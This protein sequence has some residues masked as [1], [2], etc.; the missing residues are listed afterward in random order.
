MGQVTLRASTFLLLAAGLLLGSSGVAAAAGAAD[1]VLVR[2]PNGGIQP[3]AALDAEGNL[4][5]IYFKGT[6]AAG[7]VFYVKREAGADEFSTPLQVNSEAGSAVA[8]GTI[9]G[10]QLAIGKNGRLH[11]A[12][13]GSN[14]AVPPDRKGENPMLYSRLNDAQAAFEPQRNVIQKAYGLDGGGS[15]AADREGNVFV[16]WHSGTTGEANRKV[17][18]VR[19]SDEGA[20][21]SPEQPGSSQATGA[22]GC[23]G[24]RAFADSRGTVYMLYRSARQ[25]MN[26]DMQLL[27]SNDHGKKFQ[28][29][30]IDKWP[31][32][33][34]PMS[35][36][37][38]TES[39]AGAVAAWE[40]DGKVFFAPIN[41]QTGKAGKPVSPPGGKGR[42]H[43]SVAVNSNGETLLVWA[44]GTGWDRGGALA[45]QIFDAK[46]KATPI[47]GRS[48]GIPVWGLP[49]AVAQADGKFL[50]VW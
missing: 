43:P 9:R 22:C 35:S 41:R 26:R 40:T 7:D 18:F 42:K 36:E 28:L 11:V 3:Q 24:M 29:Q 46:G 15:V 23:C 50:V 1:V 4:H 13:N 12:W 37:S 27:I 19:S 34:C 48:D 10:A 21:F 14:K 32:A 39:P 45:W 17:W 33:L 25:Q 20:T 47:K 44:E 5:L 6:P 16:T 8:V 38:L 2:T 30:Q 49:T 31:V